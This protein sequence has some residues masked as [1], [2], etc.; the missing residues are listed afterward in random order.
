MTYKIEPR[1]KFLCLENYIMDD[2]RVAYKKDNVYTSEY[3][4]CIT[5]DEYDSR[6]QMDGQDDF[7]EY[8]KPVHFG[9][10]VS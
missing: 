10:V 2:G 3:A 5:D 9:Y 8:F 6:H 7:F 1:D 4:N